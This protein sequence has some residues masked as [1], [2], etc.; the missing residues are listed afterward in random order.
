[1]CGGGA[2]GYQ[3][4]AAFSSAGVGLIYQSFHHPIYPQVGTKE[5]VAGLSIIDAAMNLGWSGIKELLSRESNAP[6]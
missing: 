3:E 5:F 2:E 6:L 4:D 1:M